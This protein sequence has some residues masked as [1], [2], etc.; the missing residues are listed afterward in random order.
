[1][2]N[3][4][5]LALCATLARD[6][7]QPKKEMV[8]RRKLSYRCKEKLSTLK[9]KRTVSEYLFRKVSGN[10]LTIEYDSSTQHAEV[11]KGK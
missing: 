8:C 9:G 1:M 10:L 2:L 11:V 5:N 3:I 4:K 7:A 6:A